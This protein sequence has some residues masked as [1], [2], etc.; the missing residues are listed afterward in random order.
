MVRFKISI[1][2][3]ACGFL[4][5]C[6]S[7]NDEGHYRDMSELERPPSV[8]VD[9]HD[10]EAASNGVDIPRRRHGKGLKDDVYKVDGESNKLRIKR[11]YD[12][13]W[14]LVDRVLQHHELKIADQDRSK[15]MY[16]V[17]YDGSG[18]FSQA[19]A[20][21][22]NH[23]KPT[24]YLLKLDSQGDETELNVAIANKEEQTDSSSAKDGTDKS[25]DASASL[26]DLLFDSLHDEVKE[27]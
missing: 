13:S 8:T 23:H 5:A 12:E 22:S 16:Y 19:T 6:A 27:D 17:E 10:T 15:G 24:I 7:S 3:L 20:L 25:N 2:L 18:L 1:F 4:T 11:P 14:L 9:K 21:F 26:T